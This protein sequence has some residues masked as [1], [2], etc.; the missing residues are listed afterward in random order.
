MTIDGLAFGGD[1][2]ARLEGKAVFVGGAF[3]GD[4]V[5]ARIVADKKTFAKAETVAVT[6]P[7]PHRR[8]SQ[9][10]FVAD[11][12]G[13]PWMELAYAEQLR[14]K[15]DAVRQSLNRIGGVDIDVA[16]TIPAPEEYGYRARVRLGARMDGDRLILGF[17]RRRSQT[18]APVTRCAVA[19]DRINEMMAAF[20][21]AARA[22]GVA[23]K[24][25]EV[26]LEAADPSLPGRAVVTMRG[27]VDAKRAEKLLA[28]LTGA[29]GVRLIST[30]GKQRADAGALELSMSVADDVRLSFGPEGFSQINPAQNKTLVATVVAWVEPAPERTIYDLYCGAGAYAIVCSLAGGAVTGVDL[31][32]GNIRDAQRNGA[33]NGALTAAFSCEDAAASAR[34]TAEVGMR[35]D[36]AIVNPP[37]AGAPET[38]RA[39]TRTVTDRIVYVSCSPPDLA[40]DAKILGDEGF[41]LTKAQPLDLFPQTSHVETVALFTKAP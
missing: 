27:E 24:I 6:A 4:V 25:V 41:V 19:N 22:A 1:G 31:S 26:A 34:K 15:T 2:V 10:P 20:P 16:D 32:K 36:A 13:C 18:L 9:C 29:A 5:T 3:P 40:R 35:F 21:E 33:A 12:G 28:G 30:S 11:C 14:W 17:H 38:V 37:R 23:D 8:A 7:S 39:L